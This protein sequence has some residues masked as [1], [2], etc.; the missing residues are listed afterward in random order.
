MICGVVALIP[1]RA[2]SKRIPG[3]NLRL[4]RGHPLLAYSVRAAIDSGAFDHVVVSTD[5]AA[6]AAVARLYG[7]DVPFLRPADLAGDTS[8]DIAWVRHAVE[9]LIEDGH[10][11]GLFSVLR[12]T[13]PLRSAAVIRAA[14]ETLLADDAADSLRAVERV[15][16]HPG[17]MWVLEQS[18]VRMRPLLDDAGAEPPWHSSAYQALPV[19]HVQNASLEVARVRC[20]EANGSIAG[21]EIIPWVMPGQE[22]FDLNTELDWL[23]LEAL[24]DRGEVALP[25]LSDPSPEPGETEGPRAWEI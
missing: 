23:L 20:L 16:Q 19:V 10:T 1:A 15:T 17:K 13:S 7:A 12:P 22:G 11:V 24:L 6:T 5:D 8:P 2:G 3:K 14:V 18:G 4:L 25:M 21:K 9:A